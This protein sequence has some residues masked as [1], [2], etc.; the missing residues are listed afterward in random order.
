LQTHTHLHTQIYTRI[1]TH[2]IKPWRSWDTN[3]QQSNET[4][5]TNH[6]PA[7]EN[8]VLGTQIIN[9]PLKL[10]TQIINQ[11]LKI[12]M[13]FCSLNVS[14]AI[15]YWSAH[16]SSHAHTR[17]ITHAHT[18]TV[19]GEIDGEEGGIHLEDMCQGCVEVL[20]MREFVI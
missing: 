9:Q 8:G 5:N 11:P 2:N 3:H 6:Q 18:S 12:V 17:F 19:V 10:T 20:T 1:Y 4:N 13:P 16:E 7:I 15:Q 14:L